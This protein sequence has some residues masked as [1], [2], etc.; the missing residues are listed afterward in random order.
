MPLEAYWK[1]AYAAQANAA[2]GTFS[3]EKKTGWQRSN[4]CYACASTCCK[5]WIGFVDS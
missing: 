4:W 3:S 1:D 5:L 2:F